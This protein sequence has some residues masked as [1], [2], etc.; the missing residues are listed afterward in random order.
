MNLFRL[1]VNLASS[2]GDFIE[3][4]SSHT[5]A[6]LGPQFGGMHT[7]SQRMTYQGVQTLNLKGR[8]RVK[9]TLSGVGEKNLTFKSQVKGAG[10]FLNLTIWRRSLS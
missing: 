3:G 5:S 8:W 1:D 9:F 6:D 7:T 2:N 10:S 4:F